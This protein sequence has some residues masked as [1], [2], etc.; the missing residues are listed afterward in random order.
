VGASLTAKTIQQGLTGQVL[1]ETLRHET[2]HSVLTPGSLTLASARLWT[3]QH[4]SI[5]RYVEEAAAETY[6]TRSL[7]QGLTFPL[8]EGYVSIGGLA[9]EAGGLGVVGL[10][11]YLGYRYASGSGG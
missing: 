7:A 10:G 5:W 11:G 3:Y 4:S 1:D 2:V 6:G 8:R 9:L